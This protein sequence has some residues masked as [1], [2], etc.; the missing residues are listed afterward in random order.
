MIQIGQN[1]IKTN[2]KKHVQRTPQIFNFLNI[3]NVQ[4]TCNYCKKYFTGNIAGLQIMSYICTLNSNGVKESSA[5]Q[6]Y[7]DISPHRCNL[8][9]I[10]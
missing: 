5:A 9:K 10:N 4:C 7:R 3:Q 6:K 2:K 8:K 1:D